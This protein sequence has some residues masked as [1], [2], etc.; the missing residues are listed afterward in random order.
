MCL[1][2]EQSSTCHISL[3]KKILLT[4]WLLASPECFRSVGNLFGM[5]KGQAHTIF[6]QICDV[7]TR[8]MKKDYV[9]WP[10]NVADYR[11]I[12]SGFE[13][14]YG[15][16]GV[17]GSVDGCHIPI[18]PPQNDRDSFINRKGSP[19]INVMAICD[20]SMKFT[21]MCIEYA[22]SV[23]DARV[24]RLTDIGQKAVSD[25]L[26]S[27]NSFHIIGDSAYPLLLS[28]MCPYRDNG[29]LSRTQ[30]KFNRI[31]SST[32]S[33]IERAFGRWKGKFRRMKY[34]DMTRT[35]NM[36]TVIEASMIMHNFILHYEHVEENEDNE[37]TDEDNDDPVEYPSSVTSA[38]KQ[39]AKQKRDDIANSL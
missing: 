23:H 11:R 36:P 24:F 19:S 17:V 34:L 8:C 15:L 2:E 1:E 21:Y 3:E 18:K 27:D 12:A 26:F 25:S 16:K 32:R 39:A 13:D 30:L 29:H 5:N 35:E 33:V 7:I 9:E 10:T 31:L 28:L 6:M 20:S 37:Y 14:M 38:Q 22:G 4:L